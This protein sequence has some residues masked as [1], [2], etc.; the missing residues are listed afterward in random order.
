MPKSCCAAIY[1]V[2]HSVAA[3]TVIMPSRP[4][5]PPRRSEGRSR[6]SAREPT[7]CALIAR[8]PPPP[9]SG[10]W[11]GEPPTALRPWITLRHTV[12]PRQ[13]SPL[14]YSPPPP[15]P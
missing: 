11:R 14:L 15:N 13:P 9:S 5:L 4:P 6:W 2:G 12:G 3:L 1:L 7:T 10:V 8:D